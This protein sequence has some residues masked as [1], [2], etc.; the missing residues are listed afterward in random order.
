MTIEQT[1]FHNLTNTCA[2]V[3]ITPGHEALLKKIRAI[4]PE[5]N[6]THVLTRGGW[7]RAGG[8][9]SE[10]GER[11][12]HNI[13]V[14]M[15]I[16]FDNNVD[17]V[18]EKYANSGCIATRLYG[19]THYFV[20][21]T[22]E[23]A[24]EFMQLEVEELQEVKDHLLISETELPDDL[25]DIV[26][27]LNAD[28]VE[29]DNVTEAYYLY[30]RITDIADYL[31]EMQSHHMGTGKDV[32]AIQRFLQDW[33]A[34]SANE[35]GPFCHHWVLSLR[36][37][38]DA[39]GEPVMQAKPISTFSNGLSLIKLKS[40]DRGSKLATII[41]TFDREIGYPMAWYFFMLSHKEVPHKLA[42]AIHS[43]LM[44]AYAYLPAKDLK[45]VNNWSSAP[46][47]V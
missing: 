47:G 2:S 13:R 34:S 24:E 4:Y 10:A 15:E 32:V 30:R 8:V 28:M 12:T 3:A 37:F 26:E 6:F 35:S 17:T 43:D 19:K 20:A 18:V 41:H 45:V 36:E 21:Q 16:E 42:E 38:N 46:Y 14:W 25:D 31:Q 5:L 9:I 33:E 44:G 22:G 40:D 7:H 29:K 39:Y 11:I 23:S 27:P 1:V